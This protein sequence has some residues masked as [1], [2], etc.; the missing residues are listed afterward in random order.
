MHV[1][2]WVWA[3][4]AIPHATPLLDIPHPLQLFKNNAANILYVLSQLKQYAEHTFLVATLQLF[5]YAVCMLV[6]SPLSLLL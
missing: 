1:C 2:R 6:E 5:L 3:T 4:P